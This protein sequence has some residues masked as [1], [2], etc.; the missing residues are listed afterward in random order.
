LDGGLTTKASEKNQSQ[1]AEAGEHGCRGLRNN[2]QF[3]TAKR[4]I[5]TGRRQR[6]QGGTCSSICNRN[7]RAFGRAVQHGVATAIYSAGQSAN[8]SG[9]RSIIAQGISQGPTPAETHGPFLDPGVS[10]IG[11]AC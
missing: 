8:S 6:R 3:Y 1:Q 7:Q 10:A 4:R 2:Q 9:R 11:V 5:G